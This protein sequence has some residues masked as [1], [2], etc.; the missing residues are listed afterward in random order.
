MPNHRTRIPKRSQQGAALLALMIVVVTALSWYMAGAVTNAFHSSASEREARTGEALRK[1]KEAVLAWVM[2]NAANAG[3]LYPGRLPCPEVLS[4]ASNL[5]YQGHAGPFNSTTAPSSTT[6]VACGAVGRLPWKTLGVD[7]LLD[8]HGEPLWFAVPTGSWAWATVDQSLTINPGSTNQLSFDGT[9][10]VVAV[11][12]APGSAMNT[13]SETETPPTPCVRVN[14]ARAE[15]TPTAADYLECGNATGSYKTSVSTLT[16]SGAYWSNDRAIGITAAEVIDAISGPVQSRIQRQVAPALSDASTRTNW[17]TQ[18]SVANWGISFL[19]FASTFSAATLNG[20]CGDIGITEGIL[21]LASSASSDCTS[22]SSGTVAS[23]GGFLP[24]V[25]CSGSTGGA[26]SGMPAAVCTQTGTEMEC[27]YWAYASSFLG[28][29]MPVRATITASAP[30]VAGA[31]RGPI[32]LAQISGNATSSFSLALDATSGAASLSLVNQA[33]PV[34][35]SAYRYTIR[36]PNLPDA[37]ILSDSRLSWFLNGGWARYTYYAL[38]SAVS[39]SPSGSCTSSGGADC[40]LMENLPASN[41]LTNDK[42]VVLTL[43]GRAVSLQVQPSDELTNYLETH[44]YGST[45]FTMSD[46][47]STSNDRHAGCPAK[48]TYQDNSTVVVCE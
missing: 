10:S 9:N 38:S 34:N 22:W 43:M 47:T 21:P 26:C 5:T 17:R 18:Q 19:P 6:A 16:A 36:I 3:E 46:V 31:F 11:I 37:A 1:A 20:L 29:V 12:I 41:G 44:S 45:S 35:F 24:G 27:I 39:A 8:G 42:V 2:V 4:L 32:T 14:Q 23:T 40:L 48:V 7:Q 13:L 15:T 25:I 30:K 33:T 28:F